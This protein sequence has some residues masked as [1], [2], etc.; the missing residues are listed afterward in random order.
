MSNGEQ[1]VDERL[2]TKCAY[3]GDPLEIA[4]GLFRKY[5]DGCRVLARRAQQADWYQNRMSLLELK[6][7][8]LYWLLGEARTEFVKQGYS[9]KEAS[10]KARELITR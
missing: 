4:D 8:E 9:L 3:C 10:E 1:A 2:V 6:K 5:H 7:A